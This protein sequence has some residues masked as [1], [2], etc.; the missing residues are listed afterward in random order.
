MILNKIL[1]CSLSIGLLS[2]LSCNSSKSSTGNY[3][4]KTECIRTEFDGTLSLITRGSGNTK[5]EAIENAKRKALI[6]VLFHGINEG[7]PECY[8]TPIILEI[9]AQKKNEAYFDKFFGNKNEYKN[10]ISVKKELK[11]L[12]K[13]VDKNMTIEIEV[14]VLRTEL[15]QKM[16]SDRIL[17]N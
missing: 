7:K 11:P 13:S 6:D 5:S 3:T 9:N 15:K 1:I 10:F 4:F 2:L 17:K 14:R 8:S 16:I 12:I